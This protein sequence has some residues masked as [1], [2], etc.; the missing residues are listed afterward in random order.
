[1]ELRILREAASLHDSRLD[2]AVQAGGT[3]WPPREPEELAA[4]WTNRGEVLEWYRSL[5]ADGIRS[6]VESVEVD[7]D[8]VVLGLSVAREAEGAAGPAR[9]ALLTSAMVAWSNS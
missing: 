8:A 3:G 6:T 7:G 5:L 2:E 1:V 9:T 4:A